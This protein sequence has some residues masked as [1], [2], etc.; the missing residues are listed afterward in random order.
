M[1]LCSTYCR[2]LCILLPIIASVGTSLAKAEPALLSG[3]FPFADIEVFYQLY[4][5]PEPE[6]PVALFLH[7]QS[8][9][10]D[11]WVQLGTLKRVWEAGWSAV[12][13]DLPGYGKTRHLPYVDD[14]MRAEVVKAALVFA[15]GRSTL[16]SVLVSPSMSGKWAVPFL[17]RYGLLLVG[18]VALAPVGVG[19]WNG[20]WEFTHRAVHL[21]AMYG[22][23]DPLKV[24]AEELALYFARATKVIV[25]NAGHAFY[26]EQPEAFHTAL[27]KFIRPF[28]MTAGSEQEE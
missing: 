16:N 26:V 23:R 2:C 25:P 27:L 19:H 5:R 9:T 28:P 11:I 18:W 22:E 10:S 7:G 1:E 15:K 17:D 21:L 8:F 4:E 3:T 12:A 20:P 13:I 14:N 6:A 24:D